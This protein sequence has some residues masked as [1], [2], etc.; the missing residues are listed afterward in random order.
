MKVGGDKIY[1]TIKAGKN[2][3]IKDTDDT[4]SGRGDVGLYEYGNS[5]YLV[6][7]DMEALEIW[8]RH[9][10]INTNKEELGGRRHWET[11]APSGEPRNYR[12][13]FLTSKG[14]HN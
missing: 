14:Q 7:I 11:R 5:K 1:G 13:A 10:N 6:I 9:R 3:G 4:G 12:M 8:Q 2:D